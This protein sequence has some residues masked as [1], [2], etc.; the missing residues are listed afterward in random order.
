MPGSSR[1]L[2]CTNLRGGAGNEAL[3]ACEAE[4]GLK[5]SCKLASSEED[6]SVDSVSSANTGA[7]EDVLLAFAGSAEAQPTSTI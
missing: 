2:H 3:E 5:D 6:M 1:S 4:D 7:V